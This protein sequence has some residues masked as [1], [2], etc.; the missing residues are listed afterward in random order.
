MSAI[1]EFKK[2]MKQ[3]NEGNFK[4]EPEPE[5]QQIQEE[6]IPEVSALEQLKALLREAAPKYVPKEVFE[7]KLEE[8]VKNLSQRDIIQMTADLLGKKNPLSEAD[9]IEA[10]RWN[11]PLKQDFVT[12]KEMTDH[13]NLLLTRV[14]TQLSSLGGGGEVNFR[15]LD[16]VN[17]STMTSS[18]NNWVLEYD[19][20][21]KKAQFT[22]NIGPIRHVNFDVT[23]LE[24]GDEQ[25]GTLEWN[26]YD[27]TLNIHHDNNVVQQVGQEQYFLMKNATGNTIP[28]G[29]VCMFEGAE[30][31]DGARLLAVPMV[32][33]GTYANQYILG[34]STEAILDQELGFVTSFG[35]VGSVNTSLFNIGDILYADPLVVGGLT[36]IKPTAPNNVISIGFVLRVDPLIGEIFVRPVVEQKL[37]YGRFSDTTNQV[38]LLANTPYPI[39]F[40]IENEALGF[41]VNG[42]EL[43]TSTI[44]CEES[45]YYHI[46]SSLSLTS[47]NASTKAFYVWLRKNSVDVP[48]SAKRQSIIGNNIFEVFNYTFTLS[49]LKDDIIEIMYATSD[50]TISITAPPATAFS[51][52]I[53]SATLL[54]TQVAL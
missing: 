5:I 18:N 49:L 4:I 23:H 32:A 38:P 37:L 20:A 33:D 34:V 22:D 3:A 41:R 30:V 46:T 13:Y 35:R 7:E 47:S 26:I 48:L 25:P 29:T 53:P 39:K 31:F 51:P 12:Q 14:Q 27:R 6:V 52:T 15:Y 2:L 24:S 42:D 19:S 17:R 21:T 36:N 10:Q 50:V 45:G 11:D 44:T 9:N 28:D 16:D 40:N 54:I 1:E 43:P 8:E